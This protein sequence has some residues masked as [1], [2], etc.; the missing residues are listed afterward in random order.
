MAGTK[1]GGRKAALT[2][3][4]RHGADFY[5]RIGADGGRKGTTGGFA[6]NPELARVAGAR[7]GRVSRRRKA[8]PKTDAAKQRGSENFSVAA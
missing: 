1:E 2:N 6:A 8:A 3:K 7:G 4:T 5:A